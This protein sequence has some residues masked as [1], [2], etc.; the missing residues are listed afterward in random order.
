VTDDGAPQA[1]AGSGFGL[2]GMV[3][4]AALLGGSCDAGPA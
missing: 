2:A 4:R 3:E 1:S